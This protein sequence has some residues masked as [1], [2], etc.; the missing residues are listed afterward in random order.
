MREFSPP[1][2]AGTSMRVPFLMASALAAIFTL[3]ACGNDESGTMPPPP[4]SPS[5]TP[6]PPPPV[7]GMLS[8][9]FAEGRSEFVGDFAEYS[10]ATDFSSFEFGSGIEPV[11]DLNIDGYL[12]T[13]V[14]RS[15]DVFMFIWR[16]F[17]GLTPNQVYR[18]NVTVTFAT[19]VPPGC[20]G[21]GGA[22]GESVQIQAGASP[23]EPELITE[24]GFV[25]A[26]FAHGSQ[27][28]NDDSGFVLGNFAQTMITGMR[29]DST[30]QYS[31]KT[32]SSTSSGTTVTADSEGRI[33]PFMGT[34]S[35]FE[36][37]TAIYFLSADYT[38][39]PVT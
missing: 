33:W 35:G 8:V 3:S 32:L 34:D 12:L 26:N 10:T 37:R 29:C 30:D 20:V 17:D 28:P 21:A 7:N 9:E 16:L 27:S 38:F 15:D 13:S 24:N 14:N 22:P 31:E 2:I 19:N 6:T 39:T 36:G 25:S 5:P 11:P 4:V 1:P 18:V 23:V